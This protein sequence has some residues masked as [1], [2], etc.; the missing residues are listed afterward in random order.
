M[1]ISGDRFRSDGFGCFAARSLTGIEP[2]SQTQLELEKNQT[3]H[4]M[5]L[6]GN[7][8]V[9]W[10]LLLGICPIFS[11]DLKTQVSNSE[12]WGTALS[13]FAPLLAKAV[14]R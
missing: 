6:F 4:S 14:R 7:P 13:S 5:D 9:E 8:S 1:A 12:T 2:N 3:Y 10:D 11:E